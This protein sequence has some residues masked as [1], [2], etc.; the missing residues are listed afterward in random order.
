MRIWASAAEG[1]PLGSVMSVLSSRA[2]NSQAFSSDFTARSIRRGSSA[3]GRPPA[4][5]RARRWRPGCDGPAWV[6]SPGF[7]RRSRGGPPALDALEVGRAIALADV[8]EGVGALRDRGPGLVEEGREGI[9]VDERGRR[10]RA[11]APARR[12]RR[13]AGAPGGR[14]SWPTSWRWS[15]D[16]RR[17]TWGGARWNGECRSACRSRRWRKG[18]RGASRRAPGG[19]AEGGCLPR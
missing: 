10:R 11:G 6:C 15:P 2:R 14:S 5:R 1:W 13:R 3:P 9:V 8:A 12:G 19:P 4:R 7:R 17:P 18:A 16:R